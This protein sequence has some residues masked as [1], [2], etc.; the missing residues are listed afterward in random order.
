MGLAQQDLDSSLLCP[1]LLLA[2]GTAAP[3]PATPSVRASF[4]RAQRWL[5]FKD[6]SPVREMLKRCE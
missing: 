1:A 6:S 4:R 2:K 5:L 3:S